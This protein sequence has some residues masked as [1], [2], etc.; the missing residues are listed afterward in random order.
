M[1]CY[2]QPQLH[3]SAVRKS[4]AD[5]LEFMSFL[6]D[7]AFKVIPNRPKKN[8]IIDI[9][10]WFCNIQNCVS[11]MTTELPDLLTQ[12]SNATKRGKSR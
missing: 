7:I 10:H 1:V 12:S 6:S 3:N 2:S 8:P 4:F 9:N 5:R 11:N